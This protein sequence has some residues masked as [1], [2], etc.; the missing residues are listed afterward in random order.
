MEANP[1]TGKKL[2]KNRGD[3]NVKVAGKAIC[4]EG[5]DFVE[6]ALNDDKDQATG[7]AIAAESEKHFNDWNAVSSIFILHY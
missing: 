2:K 3:R 7:A 6:F 5:Q 1:R 4:E